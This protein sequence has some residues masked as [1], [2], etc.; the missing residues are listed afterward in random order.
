MQWPSLTPWLAQLV[1][2]GQ[3]LAFPSTNVA[4]MVVLDAVKRVIIGGGSNGSISRR[5]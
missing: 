4:A 2:L 3:I 5:H 1:T